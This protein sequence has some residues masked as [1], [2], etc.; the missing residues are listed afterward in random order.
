MA[1]M[2]KTHDVAEFLQHMCTRA[3]C[4]AMRGGWEAR[5]PKRAAYEILDEQVTCP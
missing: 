5:R 1:G 3:E 4:L 2:V